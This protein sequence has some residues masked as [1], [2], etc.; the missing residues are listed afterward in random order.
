MLTRGNVR[1]SDLKEE[2]KLEQE[3][4]RI[5]RKREKELGKIEAESERC[6]REDG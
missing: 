1:T 2:E 5:W 4:G 3:G 6:V